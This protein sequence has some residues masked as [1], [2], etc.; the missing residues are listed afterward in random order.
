MATV[1][2]KLNRPFSQKIISIRK[3][4]DA[5]QNIW[6]K[7]GNARLTEMATALQELRKLE[8]EIK[9]LDSTRGIS[10][11][12][13]IEFDSVKLFLAVMDCIKVREEDQKKREEVLLCQNGLVFELKSGR[14]QWIQFD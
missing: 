13:M 6:Q 4:L 7:R 9:E 2:E 12:E 10:P 3:R 8:Q 1:V 11:T 14:R 5:K